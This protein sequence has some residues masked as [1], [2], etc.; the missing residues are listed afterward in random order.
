MRK[1]YC[2]AVGV[3]ERYRIE[4]IDAHKASFRPGTYYR[5]IN[6]ITGVTTK[7]NSLLAT[8]PQVTFTDVWK[9]KAFLS[10]FFKYS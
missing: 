6:P 4:K 7:A 1:K 8:K 2:E 5:L 3:L 10:G 9:Q